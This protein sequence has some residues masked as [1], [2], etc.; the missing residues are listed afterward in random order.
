M[1]NSSSNPLEGSPDC[2]RCGQNARGG[3]SR[4]CRLCGTVYC[5]S[6]KKMHM[7]KTQGA[8]GAGPKEQR[9]KCA[10]NPLCRL[11][12]RGLGACGAAAR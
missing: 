3:T 5:G 7:I 11:H 9:W 1:G 6:C 2:R 4:A 12:H 10:H 8:E